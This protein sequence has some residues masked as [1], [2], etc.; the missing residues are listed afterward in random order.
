MIINQTKEFQVWYRRVCHGFPLMILDLSH[1]LN[2]GDPERK[3][4][5]KL[6]NAAKNLNIVKTTVKKNC[7][8][9]EIK[10]DCCNKNGKIKSQV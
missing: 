8:L 1:R 4:R 5:N 2:S 7:G 3:R 6:P 9:L 10:G